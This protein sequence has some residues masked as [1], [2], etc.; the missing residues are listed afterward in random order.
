MELGAGVLRV[1]IGLLSYYFK[2][3]DINDIA[4][5]LERVWQNLE[6]EFADGN[7]GRRKRK[8]TI[9]ER[10]VMNMIDLPFDKKYNVIYG[11]WCLNYL[12][13]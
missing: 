11:N 6:P 8:G 7:I 5:S 10:Y 13:D 12:S 2:K 3:I 4:T 9:G 1:T